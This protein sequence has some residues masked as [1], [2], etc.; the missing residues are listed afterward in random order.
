MRFR[1]IL[2]RVRRGD[3]KRDQPVLGLLAQAV[4]KIYSMVVFTN[5]GS[6]E[7]NPALAAAGPTTH[8]REGTPVADSSHRKLALDGTV[9]E[10]VDTIGCRVPDLRGDVVAPRHDDVGAEVPDQLFVGT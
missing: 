1:R 3:T 8:R 4:K 7:G 5:H 6:V 9:C 2:R 10:A